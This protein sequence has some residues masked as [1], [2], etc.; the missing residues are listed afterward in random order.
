MQTQ[1]GV[2]W[3]NSRC[4]GF[5]VVSVCVLIMDKANAQTCSLQPD[6]SGVVMRVETGDSLTLEDGTQVVLIGALPPASPNDDGDNS[7][8]WPPAQ[9]TR[10]ALETLVGGR[11]VELAFGGRRV[12]RYGRRLA[13]VFVGDGTERIWVQGELLAKGLARAYALPGSDG[14]LDPMILSEQAARAAQLG[15]WQAGLF[16]DKPAHQPSRLYNLKD[17]FQSVEGRIAVASKRRGQWVLEFGPDGSHAGPFGGGTDGQA[18]GRSNGRSGFT[19]WIAPKPARSGRRAD[20]VAAS[21]LIG[22]RVRVRGWIETA[23]GP[24][25]TVDS[26]AQL[27]L[28]DDG[29]PWLNNASPDP[30]A[31]DIPGAIPTSSR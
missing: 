18:V 6:R 23:P 24:Q 2:D 1:R 7:T 10:A 30:T 11:S 8:P 17:T 27:E 19:V 4:I 13:H 20:T 28:L 31:T 21:D 26:I 3:L 22:R 14:C 16:Q 12:D 9:T 29:M 5:A 15:H 25:I